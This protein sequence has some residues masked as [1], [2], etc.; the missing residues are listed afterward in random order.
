M[1]WNSSAINYLRSIIDDKAVPQIIKE[2]VIFC[3]Q[4]ESSFFNQ[5]VRDKTI[6]PLHP[7]V[8]CG[9]QDIKQFFIIAYFRADDR[10]DAVFLA[11]L[12]EVPDIAGAIDVGEGQRSDALL[13]SGFHQTLGRE[14]AVTEA[15]ICFTV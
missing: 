10:L 11:K 13:H 3:R 9:E 5:M 14:S 4:G 12:H 15:E 7:F 1:A 2:G 6:D 8:V